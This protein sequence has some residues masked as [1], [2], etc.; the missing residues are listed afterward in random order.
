MRER[1]S[2]QPA[3]AP[4]VVRWAA[5]SV[6]PGLGRAPGGSRARVLRGTG[7]ARRIRGL[8]GASGRPGAPHLSGA[9]HLFCQLPQANGLASAC[10][11]QYAK[12]GL[13][14]VA[15]P[16]PGGVG[17]HCGEPLA[18]RESATE[19]PTDW[20]L[21]QTMTRTP[22]GLALWVVPRR[23]HRVLGERLS[24]AVETAGDR[25]VR[26]YSSPRVI[27]AGTTGMMTPSSASSSA[28]GSAS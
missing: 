27:H 3:A 13:L 16:V 7:A 25:A 23:R 11:G 19:F 26:R 12:S 10:V 6:A 1:A 15:V 9:P 8:A 28:V 4:Y 18:R 17:C 20:S 24:P 5:V 14:R 21:S 22:S 2:A